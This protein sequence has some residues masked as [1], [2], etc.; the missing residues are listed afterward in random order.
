M[1]LVSLIKP[2]MKPYFF[3]FDMMFSALT[4]RGSISIDRLPSLVN[5]QGEKAGLN[6]DLLVLCL[7]RKLGSILDPNYLF[8][9][10]SHSAS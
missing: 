6:L 7:F 10:Y 3:D 4:R 5:E 2:S 1:S 9:S 8:P